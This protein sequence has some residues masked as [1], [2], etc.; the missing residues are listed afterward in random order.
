[1]GKIIEKVWRGLIPAAMKKTEIKG[2]L[3][4][5]GGVLVET[6]GP[7]SFELFAQRLRRNYG[8]SVSGLEGILEKKVI[9]SWNRGRE[10]PDVNFWRKFCTRL[11]IKGAP[12]HKF[13]SFAV[14]D[15]KTSTKPKEGV[16]SLVKRLKKK[17]KLGILSNTNEVAVAVNKKRGMFR[18]FAVLIFSYKAKSV[19]PQRK[20]YQIAA[21]KMKLPPQNLLFIDDKL[22]NVRASQKF[23]M[24]AIHFRSFPQLKSDLKKLNII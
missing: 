17:Y 14:Q 5:M 21:K 16:L 4:D 7:K 10:N 11:R 19:K 12:L 2:I 1:L 20:I 15:Y 23:G 6:P 3:F 13:N 9:V 18:D 24:K 22:E 8:V